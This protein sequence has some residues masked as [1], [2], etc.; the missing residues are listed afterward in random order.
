M[1]RLNNNQIIINYSTQ[2]SPVSKLSRI[3]FRLT[4]AAAF[5]GG[6]AVSGLSTY[7]IAQAQSMTQAAIEHPNWAQLPGE[8]IRPDC[9]HEIPKGARVEIAKDGNLTGDVTLNGVLIA[10]YDA[11]PEEAIITRQGARAQGVGQAQQQAQQEVTGN[12]WVEDDQWNAPVG[13]SD[14]IDYVGSNWTVPEYPS[15]VGGQ[16]I[17]L[18]NGIEPSSHKWF[19]EAA[20]EWGYNG[21]FG[22]NYYT[23]ET[24]L[25]GPS[26]VYYTTP[27]FVNAGDSLTGY[28]YM[29]AES[30]NTT[31]WDSVIVDNST[32][33]Y[34]WGSYW[35]SGQHW[36]WAYAGILQAFNLNSC[37]EFP[38]SPRTSFSDAAVAHGFPNY[39]YYSSPNW[40][41]AIP[42][43]GGPSCHFAVVAASATLDY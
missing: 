17:Y 26:T 34:S 11:C 23:I 27:E 5:L 30:G 18:S 42:G 2:P 40:K 24:L 33:N 20:L 1:E 37:A 16:V 41:G 22:G 13:G 3:G 35:V 25:I 32:G 9:V 28:S 8:L 31:Y 14:N 4:L 19:L 6:L 21:A 36:T 10:H 7:A 38:G 39:D 15:E 29:T 12:G 43:Y